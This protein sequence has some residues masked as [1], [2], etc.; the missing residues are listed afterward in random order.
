[1]TVTGGNRFAGD[2]KL[3]RAAE[4]TSLVSLAHGLSFV[5]TLGSPIQRLIEK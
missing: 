1:M 3:D 2:G 4:T 5:V